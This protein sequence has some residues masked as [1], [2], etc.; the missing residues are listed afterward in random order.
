MVKKIPSQVVLGCVSYV[1]LFAG[2]PSV[3]TQ[4]LGAE[5]G[6]S[7]GPI[8]GS[9]V[10]DLVDE[11]YACHWAATA[12][13]ID[14]LASDECWK[15]APVVSN[16]G[17]P[18]FKGVPAVPLEKVTQAKL[19]WDREFL[20][21]WAQLEDRDLQGKL[22][23][24]DAQTW[25]DDCFEL[26]LKPS[27]HHTGYY[28]FHVTPSNTQLDLYI[29]ERT[30]GAYKLYKDAHA[31]D[32]TSAVVCEG[33]ID[34]RSD[35]DV[36]WQVEFKI[37]WKDFW[38][39]GG[40]P[41][42]EE[43]WRYS[44]C[45]YDYDSNLSQP[46]LTTISPLTEPSFHRHEEFA[47]IQFLA[48]R[49]APPKELSQK[50]SRGNW[51]RKPM[52]TSRVVGSPE[53]PAPFTTARVDLG[54]EID[55][56]INLRTEP[57][58]GPSLERR[59]LWLITQKNPYGPS[60]LLRL[61]PAEPQGYRM[62][63]VQASTGDRV[64]YD[65]CFHP[66]FPR[67]PYLFL[68][69]NESVDGVKNS[70]VVR[71]ELKLPTALEIDS[72]VEVISEKVILQ[73][74][75]DGHNGAAMT[76]GLDGMLYITSG[77]GTTDSDTNLRGQDLTELTAKVLRI[78]VDHSIDGKPY[79]IP[80]DNPFIDRKEARPETWAYGLRNP[81][82][83]ATDSHSGRIWIG[84]NGQDLWEQVYLLKRGAN[85]GWSV[86]E[87]AS[88]FYANRKAGP[89]PFELPVMDHHHSQARSLTGGIVYRGEHLDFVAFVGDY[90][91]GDYSTG[92]IWAIKHD[93]QNASKAREVADT[94][95]AITAFEQVPTG[96][97]WIADHLGKSIVRLVPNPT[98][99][100]SS[101]FP[102]LLSETGLFED[103]G[104]HEFAS[105]VIPYSVNSPLWSD[106][107]AKVR[108]FAIPSDAE[109]RDLHRSDRRI[110]FQN[111]F[112]W[113]FP[114]DTV[115]I[116]SFSLDIPEERVSGVTSKNRWIETRLMVRQQNE[117]VGYSYRWN[118]EGTDAVLVSSEG[119]DARYMVRDDSV[120]A[121]IR[122]QVW[123]YPSRAECMVC[124]SR[125]ANFTLGL[126]TAQLNRDHDYGGEKINQLVAYERLGLLKV[127]PQ[128]F[129]SQQSSDA[130]VD[131]PVVQQSLR[132]PQR[133][134]PSDSPLLPWGPD[135]LPR[136]E[137]PHNV[138]ASLTARVQAYL[139]SNCASC[140]APAGGGNSAMDL[141]F[142]NSVEK[143][144]ILDVLA[145]HQDFGIDGAKLVASG[146]PERSILLE[147][148]ARR[149]NG[150]MP[151]IASNVVDRDAVNL[152]KEWI[153]SLSVQPK[154]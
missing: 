140:H 124:H 45:R 121:G 139:H 105:G 127:N 101:L 141:Q 47:K 85:Y 84:Q 10:R 130:P 103:V 119:E 93:G 46:V 42:P 8:T 54:V 106:G 75:S 53:A 68:G 102:K 138:S 64:H 22:T 16:F 63:T 18:W 57:S 95:H 44:L 29:P 98:T 123:H 73:W 51:I 37:A 71:L 129:V 43:V 97:I 2:V 69:L 80:K 15:Q 32:F 118:E 77:D 55:H 48:P 25:L 92:K 36:R 133:F 142:P 49:I 136:L 50:D 39:T 21:G 74:P 28:E 122:E 89:D 81:W 87:G 78:D 107:A 52:T 30:Q 104:K 56:P 149:G 110:E 35:R 88:V 108:A 99:D 7:N 58:R 151:P 11:P 38:R 148:I 135:R 126:Q 17:T 150:Q 70:R 60:E 76:F 62:Q 5:N 112:G 61:L 146:D 14:G 12:P 3:Q 26:F 154:E 1:F 125:A 9:A 6:A 115:L 13:T 34:E 120:S 100:T 143:M 86:M 117:W 152:L 109:D 83:I 4:T 23:E 59:P 72:L 131:S 132:Q 40:S 114:N 128:Q 111:Q 33:T 147:R 65:L 41:A 24:H 153:G 27:E 116:K 94:P 67:Q 113:T 20:Y 145:K 82:R 134:V 96:E 66:D 90:F 91:Y 31:F 79:S 19:V 137:N 144:G